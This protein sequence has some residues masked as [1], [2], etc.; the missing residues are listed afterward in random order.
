MRGCCLIKAMASSIAMH[1]FVM[2]CHIR[3]HSRGKEA[4]CTRRK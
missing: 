4:R 2:R 1:G 3:C